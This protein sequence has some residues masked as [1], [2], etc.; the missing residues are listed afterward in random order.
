MSEKRLP[1]SE[2]KG[3][4]IRLR[5]ARGEK[6]AQEIA[7]ELGVSHPTIYRW[8]GG[9]VE[10]PLEYLRYAVN[11][12]GASSVDW[13]LTGDDPASRMEVTAEELA[14]PVVTVPDLGDLP[15]ELASLMED[16]A[17]AWPQLAEPIRLLVRSG[18]VALRDMVLGRG[19]VDVIPLGLVRPE[20]LSYADRALLEKAVTV[21]RSSKTALARTLA[22]MIEQLHGEVT[23]PLSTV[24]QPILKVAMPGPEDKGGQ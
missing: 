12:L 1:F 6:S 19:V 11:K 13:L 2:L 16:T 22:S 15:W 17:R 18:A 24:A 14:P 20:P 10:P 23:T 5:L 3:L 9:S 7:L 8:E 4:G 21:L